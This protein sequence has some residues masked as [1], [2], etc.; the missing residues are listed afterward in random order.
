RVVNTAALPRAA[1]ARPQRFAGTSPPARAYRAP[2]ARP[3][4]QRFPADPPT[5][6]NGAVRPETNRR[7]Q[8]QIHSSAAPQRLPAARQA[9]SRPSAHG[10]D[11]SWHRFNATAK[12]G[13]DKGRGNDKGK[14]DIPHR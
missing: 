9:Q 11:P 2:A 5:R 7:Q 4:F 12:S 1:Q 14:R 3:G 13:N 6:S 10:S 8:P